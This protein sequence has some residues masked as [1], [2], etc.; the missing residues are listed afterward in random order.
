MDKRLLLEEI[1]MNK[2]A[3]LDTFMYALMKEAR[4]D[5][6]V[7]FLEVWGLDYDTDFEEIKKWFKDE[8]GIKL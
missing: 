1:G 8:L 7:E 3:K 6:L 5:S 4:R 2:P